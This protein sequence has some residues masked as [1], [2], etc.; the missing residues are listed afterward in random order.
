MHRAFTKFTICCDL[1]R[2]RE[3]ICGSVSQIDDD[4]DDDDDDVCFVLDRYN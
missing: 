2:L 4:G 3:C 1:Y